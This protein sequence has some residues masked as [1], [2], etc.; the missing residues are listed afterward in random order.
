MTH[1]L[2]DDET[3]NDV[4]LKDKRH[5]VELRP[6]CQGATDMKGTTITHGKRDEV[7]VL[8]PVTLQA[9]ALSSNIVF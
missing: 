2:A 6:V 5:S 9:I 8:T 3:E 1:N 7:S 4:M